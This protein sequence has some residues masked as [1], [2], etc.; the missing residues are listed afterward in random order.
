[1]KDIIINT[2]KGELNIEVIHGFIAGSYWGRGR[3]IEQTK[4]SINNSL[5]FGAYLETQQIGYARVITDYTLFAYLLDVFI[6]ESQR[7]KGYSKKLMNH[8]MTH[9]KLKNIENWKLT[10]SDAHG[11]Y[12]KYGFEKLQHPAT[13][14]ERKLSNIE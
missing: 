1:M 11:L 6:I 14:M 13:I 8:I 4:K 10:T 12:Q 3:T 9:P 5:N 7:G 2:E